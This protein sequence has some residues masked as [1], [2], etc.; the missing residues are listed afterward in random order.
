MTVHK[1][2]MLKRVTAMVACMLAIV[3]ASTLFCANPAVAAEAANLA[4]NKTAVADSEEAGTVVAAKAVDGSDSTRWGSAEDSAGGAHWIYVDLGSSKTVKKATIKWESYKATGYKIQYATGNTAPAATSSDWKDIHTS[5]DRPASL[6]D[7]ITFDTPVSGRFFRLYIT[8]FT[9]HDPNGAAVDWPTIAVNEFEL[10]GDETVAPSTQDPQQNVAR[11]VNATADSVEA[12]TLGAAKAVDGNTTSSS[13]RWASAVDATASRDGGPHWIYVDLGQQRDVKCVRVFWELRKAKG[14]KIQI[15]NGD[16]APAADSSDWQT[17]YTNNGHPSGKIDLITLDQVH[18]ARF[19]R[20]YIDH[21]TYADPDGGVAWGNV[22]IYELEVFGGTPKMDMNGLADAIKVEAPKKGDTQ[23]KVTLP[24]SDEYDVTYNGTDYEQVVGAQANDGTIPI[25]QPIV[26]TQVK[27]SFKVTKKS[28]KNTYTFKEVPVTVPGKFQVEAGDNAAPEVLP[29]L[30]EWKG[31][32]GSF[33]PSAQTRV[34][35]DSDDFKTAADELAADYKD[36]F[37]SELTV[38]KGSAANAGDIFLSKT[39]DKSLGLQ[40][41]G[42]LMEI[43]DSVSVKAETKTGA[44]VH[45]YH[46]AGSQDRQRLHP[47][48]NHPRLPALQGA[49]PDSRRGP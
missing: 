3:F 22:S 35:Y 31:R 41:E 10:Y 47:A 14:Y 21:N 18:R 34:V 33:A 28:D 12:N 13:S 1:T 7:E 48:G 20:L 11:G 23:L 36:L 30:R 19:V 4:L 45:P 39:S 40:D 38:V 5:S 27:V 49:R 15:A 32:S 43:T 17:V 9:S 44:L 46:P 37:G 26:D 42:Y 29:Q 24:A 2:K 25:H 8:G 6:T 16:S